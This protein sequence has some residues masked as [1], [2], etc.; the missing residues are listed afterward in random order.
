VKGDEKAVV[1]NARAGNLIAVAVLLS[2]AVSWACGGGGGEISEAEAR[3]ALPR[4]VLQEADVPDGLQRAGEDFTTNEELAQSGI[5]G[6]PE[7]AKIEEWGR[8]LGYDTDFQAAELPAGP[9]I[10]GIATAASVY[11]ASEGASSSFEDTAQRARDA[12]WTTVH[13]DLQEFEEREV[14]RDLPAD[15]AL[16]L[17]LTGLRPRVEGEGNVLVVDDQIIYR[18]GQVRGHLRV[19]TSEDGGDDRDVVL[20]QVEAML[21]TQ[22]QNT[23]DALRELD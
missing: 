18:V 6:G 4:M 9:L 2:A 5:G 13:A 12:D 3:L 11:K 10:T 16:W 15:G 19:L 7:A 1:N 8:L 14:Q 23:R 21:R 20:S 22:I 17:R